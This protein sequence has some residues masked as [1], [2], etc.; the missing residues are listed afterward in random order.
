MHDPAETPNV[1]VLYHA[2]CFDGTG[3]RYAAWRKFK[4][5][6]TYLPV[7][8]GK[9]FPEEV[10]LTRDTAIY[11]LDFSYSA[12][13]LEDVFSKVGYLRVLDH[14]KTAQEALQGLSYATFDMDKSGAVLAWEF[15]HP[16]I[17]VPL[18]LENV[19]DGD[20]W[21]FKLDN[22]KAIRAALPLLK[23]NMSKWESACRRGDTYNRLV[24]QGKA[25]MFANDLKVENVLRN[26]VKILP[27]AG[28]KAAVYN[29]TTLVSETGE[30]AYNSKELGVDLSISYFFDRDGTPILSFRSKAPHG[31]DVSAL[32]AALGGGGHKHAAGA[33]V[34]WEVLKGIYSGES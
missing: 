14:H 4:D 23:S 12:N 22:T 33:K 16:D 1:Y 29:T 34:N 5:K 11:I 26:N 25:I 28:Y 13:E 2:N 32:A 9:P 19:Q 15:F 3:A 8:Y 20:L 31:P 27:Y 24:S 17:K 6:A 30:A 10:P 7:Q 18:L 21:Q